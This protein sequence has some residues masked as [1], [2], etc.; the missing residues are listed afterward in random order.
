VLTRM[1]PPFFAGDGTVGPAEEAGGG[2]LGV[3]VQGPGI[4]RAQG[5]TVK[6]GAGPSSF[7]GALL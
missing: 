1:Q 5:V 7:R 6:P 2:P 3:G 4:R